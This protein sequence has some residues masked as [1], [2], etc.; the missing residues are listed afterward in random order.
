MWDLQ[1]RMY[2][3]FVNECGK[4]HLSEAQIFYVQ[5]TFFENFAHFTALEVHLLQMGITLPQIQHC[6]LY[7]ALNCLEL[8]FLIR[9][10]I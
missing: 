4:V 2:V 8:Y 7:I 6:T 9:E 10:N 5:N 1:F 3:Q